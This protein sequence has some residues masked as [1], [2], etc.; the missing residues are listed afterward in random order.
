MVESKDAF[1]MFSTTSGVH[2]FFA[3]E[4]CIFKTDEENLNTKTRRRCLNRRAQPQLKFEEN[5]RCQLRVV[6]CHCPRRHEPVFLDRKQPSVRLHSGR[7]GIGMRTIGSRPEIVAVN[8]LA[9]MIEPLQRLHSGCGLASRPFYRRVLVMRGCTRRNQL[10]RQRRFTDEEVNALLRKHS[11]GSDH[12]CHLFCAA[13]HA[14]ES[15]F[16]HSG[17]CSGYRSSTDKPV[18]FVPSLGQ[19]MVG[20]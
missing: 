2:H 6:P 14:D 8:A 19:P 4:K 7:P 12:G 10:L 18:G 13:L 9:S 3:L 15:C 5:N 16:Q 11:M 20:L 1:W 17:S